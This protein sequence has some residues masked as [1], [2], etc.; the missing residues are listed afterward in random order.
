MFGRCL[1]GVWEVFGVCLGIVWEVVGK[2]LGGFSMRL[3][4]PGASLVTGV[5]AA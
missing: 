4:S 3:L 2:C 5:S 1:E